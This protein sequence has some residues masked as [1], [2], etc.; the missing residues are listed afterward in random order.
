MF[1]ILF[2][3]LKRSLK[4][5]LVNL[6]FPRGRVP[7]GGGSHINIIGYTVMKIKVNIFFPI[8]FL[9]LV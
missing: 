3:S 5:N 1:G 9:V 6:I 4:R 8:T 7:G 2:L